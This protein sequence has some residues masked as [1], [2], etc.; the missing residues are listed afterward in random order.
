MVLDADITWESARVPTGIARGKKVTVS[1][2]SSATVLRV[3]TVTC[4]L[5]AAVLLLGTVTAVDE[6]SEARLE[7]G[8]TTYGVLAGDGAARAFVLMGKAHE[9]RFVRRA[10]AASGRAGKVP[11][12][13]LGRER[14][15]FLGTHFALSTAVLGQDRDKRVRSVSPTECG[16]E[17]AAG[18]GNGNGNHEDDL[19]LTIR[20]GSLR[21]MRQKL[22]SAAARFA[23]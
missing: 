10:Y 21:A 18:N 12:T 11:W 6:L 22:A 15:S 3:G 20:A 1:G 4:D 19:V 9:E 7:N 17:A 13:E 16:D 2:T 5:D 8:D 14:P 23:A